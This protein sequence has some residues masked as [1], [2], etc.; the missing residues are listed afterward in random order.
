LTKIISSHSLQLYHNFV[1]QSIEKQTTSVDFLSDKKSEEAI[2]FSGNFI[3]SKN[4]LSFAW[5]HY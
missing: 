3:P 2:A 1:Q 5:T 4:I